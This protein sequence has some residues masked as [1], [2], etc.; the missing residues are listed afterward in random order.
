MMDLVKA[1]YTKEK[2]YHFA[3]LGDNSNFCNQRWKKKRFNDGV[4]RELKLAAP[5]AFLHK[6]VLDGMSRWKIDLNHQ[7][8]LFFFP[9]HPANRPLS[10]FPRWH[11]SRR[12]TSH[13]FPTPQPLDSSWL[14]PVLAADPVCAAHCPSS[15]ST[16]TSKDRGYTVTPVHLDEARHCPT[17]ER[18][19]GSGNKPLI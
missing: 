6:V 16:L 12:H 7:A 3:K 15:G 19:G 9:R 14:L 4:F 2:I 17:G 13:L 18:S 8:L 5:L 1:R 11:R 10:P